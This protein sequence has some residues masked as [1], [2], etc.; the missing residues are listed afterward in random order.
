MTSASQRPLVFLVDDDT[1]VCVAVQR[2][3]ASSGIEARTFQSASA[4]DAGLAASDPSCLVVDVVMPDADAVTR[5]IAHLDAGIPVIYISA[6]HEPKRRQWLYE[7]GA[8]RCLDKP[9]D[10]EEFLEAVHEAI[11]RHGGR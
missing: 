1:A 2:L 10:A 11:A 3:L 8:M 5:R 6:F 7:H 4:L 9:L